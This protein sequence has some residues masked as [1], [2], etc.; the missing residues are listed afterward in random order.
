[1]TFNKEVPASTGLTVDVLDDSGNLLAANV[2]SGTNL[3]SLGISQPSVKLRANLTTSSSSVTPALLDWSLAY[4][5]TPQVGCESDWSLLPTQT[6]TWDG[7]GGD[8]KWTTAANWVGDVKPLAGD[9]L[10]FPAGAARLNN[11]NDYPANAI[12][13][14]ITISGGNYSIQ[15]NPIKSTAVEVQGNA[16]LT[17]SSIIC[18]TLTIGAIGGAAGNSNQRGAKTVLTKVALMNGNSIQPAS[19]AV[20][21]EVTVAISD[22]KEVNLTFAGIAPPEP[23]NAATPTLEEA[24]LVEPVLAVTVDQQEPRL[25]DATT[26]ASEMKAEVLVGH[27]PSAELPVFEALRSTIVDG[28]SVNPLF[29]NLLLKK[30]LDEAK[31]IFLTAKLS[32]PSFSGKVEKRLAYVSKYK[33]IIGTAA[34]RSVF[35]DYGKISSADSVD[36]DLLLE[37]HV[38]KPVRQFE[39]AIDA[40]LALD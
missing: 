34:L 22:G 24:I 1:L 16:I 13:G 12:F 38:G 37:K 29:N 18:D 15:N 19:E 33:D 21:V 27:L 9:N 2:S 7:G 8:N 31:P 10:V 39:K 25:S 5:T 3:A 26:F 35:L 40:V 4:K 17:A 14:S 36:F 30:P 23:S 28:R 20:A 6:A 11:I 32:T